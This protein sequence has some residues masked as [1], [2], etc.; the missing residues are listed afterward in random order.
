[1]PL[2]DIGSY[3]PVMNE[4]SV[5]WIA[6]NLAL[7][8]APSSDLKLEGGFTHAM[9]LLLRDEIQAKVSAIEGWENGRQIAV[10]VRDALKIAIRD[11]L[12]QFRGI[13]RVVLPKS[14]YANAA[15]VLP[16]LGFGESKFMSAFEDAADLWGRINA[17]AT[18]AGF[19]PP[20]VIAG[21][22]L[23]TFI[24]DIAAMRAAF[25]AVITAENDKR[26]GIRQ[27]DVLLKTASD[28]MV[29]YRT[30]VEVLLG[31]NHP[32]TQTL[33]V[34]YGPAGSTPD[35]V[36]LTGQWNPVTSQADFTWTPSTNP[37]LDSYQMRMSRSSTYDAATAVVIGNFPPGTTSFSTTEGLENPGDVASYKIFVILTTGNEAGS[38]TVTITRS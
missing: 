22:T 28:Y 3:V 8:G 32:L 16:D 18:I 31:E 19:T 37:N 20:L 17:D 15:P 4:F 36:N 21:Y 25:L 11:H 9:F 14:I 34:L 35:P 7:G 13:L 26:L 24:T 23:A 2:D 5:H 12:S 29:Q 33:P 6:V 10:N 1:M 30:M 27:R 38:N